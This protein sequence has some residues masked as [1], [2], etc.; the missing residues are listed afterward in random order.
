MIEKEILKAYVPYKTTLREVARI[1]NTDHHRVKRV[2][3]KNGVEV[4]KG[5]MGPFT[6]EHRANISKGCKGR[7]SWNKGRKS[8]TQMIY[9]N[10]AAHLRFDIDWMWLSQF[11]DIEKLK[12]LNNCITNREGSFEVDA[13]WYMQ[14]ILK[15][16]SDYQFNSIYEKWI[17]S[18]KEKYKK[19]S[20][21]HINP[22]SNG[23]LNALDN[24]QFLSWFEN[25][26]KNNMSQSDWDLLK[27]KISDYFI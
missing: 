6:D 11:D 17:E 19:P 10:M 4:V 27:S 7:G 25:R 13:E 16:Y 20:I 2:L 23:G 5:K 18:G 24:I 12:C 14:Y 26:C 9:K 21:D 15:F 1:C 22:R 8:T 3:I